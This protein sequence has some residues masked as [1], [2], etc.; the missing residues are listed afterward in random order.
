MTS[1]K[2]SDTLRKALVSSKPKPEEGVGGESW[3]FPVVRWL[4]VA[5]AWVYWWHPRLTFHICSQQG[6]VQPNPKELN[7]LQALS[8]ESM[9]IGLLMFSIS[10]L[11]S[12]VFKRTV[13]SLNR[14][15]ALTSRSNLL[16]TLALTLL[17]NHGI[18]EHS[19]QQIHMKITQEMSAGYEKQGVHLDE[20]SRMFK[21]WK[22][23]ERQPAGRSA[24]RED[25]PQGLSR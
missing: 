13:R 7:K 18:N 17:V 24:P 6:G 23:G 19:G 8:G 21:D 25:P 3:Y 15:F 10:F 11:G 9:N 14:A 4:P 20:F 16:S 2:M 1:E 12:V 5:P 22:R